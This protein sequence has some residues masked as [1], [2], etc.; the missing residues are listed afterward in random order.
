MITATLIA[1]AALLALCW[2]SYDLDMFRQHHNYQ[3]FLLRLESMEGEYTVMDERWS[4]RMVVT[5]SRTGITVSAAGRAGT[6][7]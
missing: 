6:K 1:L 5:H 7:L 4:L 3:Q 2:T